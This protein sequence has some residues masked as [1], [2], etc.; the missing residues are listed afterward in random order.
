MAAIVKAVRGHGPAAA[1]A[2]ADL[3]RGHGALRLG[4]ARPALRPGAERH[5]GPVG[6]AEFKVFNEVVAPAGMVKGLRVPGGAPAFPQGNGRAHRLAAELRRQGPG[7]VQGGRGRIGN[8]HLAKFFTA[9]DSR[10]RSTSAWKART[11]DMLIFV[12]D[13]RRRGQQRA[14]QAAPAAGAAPE[15]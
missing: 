8:R 12:A 10:R 2:A 7:L 3:R 6:Q 5:H 1:L 11:G 13:T 9:G 14:G 15:T 4:Q